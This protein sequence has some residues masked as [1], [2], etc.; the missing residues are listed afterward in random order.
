MNRKMSALNITGGNS[1]PVAKEVFNSLYELTKEA[2]QGASTKQVSAYD[3]QEYLKLSADDIT[4]SVLAKVFADVANVETNKTAS[5]RAHY[6]AWDTMTVPAN[7]FYD[8]QPAIPTTVGRFFA[9]KFILEG[10]GTIAGV[11]YLNI[12]LNKKAIGQMD[13]KIGQLYLEDKID[14]KMFNSYTDHRDTIGYWING[15]LAHTISPRMAKPLPEIEKKKAELCKKYEK[16]IAAGDID[17]MTKI[18]E[19]LV[20]YAKEILKDDPGMDLYISG[21][22]DFG[23]NYKNNSIIKGAVE[24]KIDDK[25]DFIETS[26]MDGIEI[27]DLPAHANS[28]LAS[29]YPASIATSESGYMGKKLLALLQMMEVDEP[30]SDCGTKNL[31]PVTINNHNKN[32]MVYSWIEDGGN[33]TMITPENVGSYVGKRVRMRSPMSC[34]GDKICSK[35]AGQLFYLLGIKEAGL[36]SVQISHASLNLGLKSKHNSNVSIFT[37]SPDS[38]I[39]DL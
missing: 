27:K 3:A 36:Y 10:S 33:L 30:G 1:K 38:L 12:T 28:I 4:R 39:E 2:P 13:S 8:K 32:E 6:N 37:L 29:Q 5:H 20:A 31:I 19:E 18:S 26:F 15:M 35:C 7:Y 25:Y 17:V 14:R 21:D 23:N 24:N 9:N 16:E 22:L 34:T 11:G